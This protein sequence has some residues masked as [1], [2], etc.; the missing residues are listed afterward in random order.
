M[1]SM[2]CGSAW[3]LGGHA[4]CSFCLLLISAMHCT[5]LR[6]TRGSVVSGAC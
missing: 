3:R 5:H 4:A 2:L 1:L 6:S